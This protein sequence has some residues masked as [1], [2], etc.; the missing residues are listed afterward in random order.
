VAR[1]TR[2]QKRRPNG[3]GAVRQLPS[4]RW[5][6]RYADEDGVLRPASTTF[7]TKIDAIHWLESRDPDEMEEQRADPRLAEY[8]KEWLEFRDLA[9]R[10]RE[11]YEEILRRAIVPPLGD[12]RVSKMTPLKVRRWYNGLD[13]ETPTVRTHTYLLLHAIFATAVSDDVISTNPCRIKGAG[14]T[15]VVHRTTVATLAEL[16]VIVQAMPGRYK[17]MVDLAAWC[18]LRFGEITE[19]R[20]KDVVSGRLHVERGV[21]RVAGE[22]VVGG[23]KTPAGRRTIAVPPHLL[24]AL[25]EHLEKYVTDNPE[26]LLFPAQNG[27]HL[28]PSTFYRGYYRAREAAGRPDLRFH[29]LRHTGATMAAATGATLKELMI[30]MGHATPDASMRYQ[31]AIQDR[32]D[33]IAKSLSGFAESGF[34]TLKPPK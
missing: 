10:T 1:I 24:G 6:A 7:E 32:D 27:G 30:R 34:I 15:K 11:K 14:T 22:F 12:V 3:A 8:A 16:L 21:V 20:R 13:P 18:G 19:L 31:H 26:A 28:A 5:Q 17:M 25:S 33:D 23:P 2:K 9:P 4:R 29:D